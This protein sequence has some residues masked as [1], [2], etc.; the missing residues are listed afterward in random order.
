ME[1]QH[2]QQQAQLPLLPPGEE[3]INAATPSK[4]ALTSESAA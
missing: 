3:I 2:R 1:K 4:D